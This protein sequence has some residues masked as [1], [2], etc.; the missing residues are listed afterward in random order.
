MMLRNLLLL[1]EPTP[2]GLVAKEVACG[3]A[4]QGNCN[5]TG[6]EIHETDWRLDQDNLI[7]SPRTMLVERIQQLQSRPDEAKTKAPIQ[8][9]QID[10]DNLSDLNIF[11]HEK[12]LSGPKYALLCKEAEGNDLTVIGR[13]DNVGEH[14]SKDAKEIINLMLEY[15]P[16]PIIITPPKFK[17]ERDVLIACDGS[18]GSSRAVQL[19]VLMGLAGDRNIHV[20]S[21]NRKKNVAKTRVDAIAA[22]LKNH[23]IGAVQYAIDSRADPIDI[24]VEKI[25]ETNSALVV[26][27]AFG[28]SVWRRSVF[29]SVSEYLIRYCPVPLFS[30]Q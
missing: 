2:S 5:I 19:F 27:G 25:K 26:A 21:V 18:P 11:Y 15:R 24:I 14:W 1:L 29:G 23:R 6:L 9:D 20:L 10:L 30:C 17:P 7:K 13:D 28:S 12:I 4:A 16:K 3:I 22:Y 8:A